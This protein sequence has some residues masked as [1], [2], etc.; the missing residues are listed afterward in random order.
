MVD[1]SSSRKT[2]PGGLMSIVGS[3]GK[4]LQFEGYATFINMQV[5]ENG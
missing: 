3:I 5:F 2:N 1:Q 4:N